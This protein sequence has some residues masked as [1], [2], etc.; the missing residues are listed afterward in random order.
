MSI[1]EFGEENRELRSVF[2]VFRDRSCIAHDWT[3][4]EDDVV[5]AGD[6]LGVFEF[7]DG[8]SEAIVAPTA[9]RIVRLFRPPLGTLGGRPS[10]VLALFDERVVRASAARASSKRSGRKPG[11]KTPPRKKGR[12]KG[13]NRRGRR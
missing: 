10:Q 11:R 8:S 3:A 2:S 9:G 7:D 13:G 4:Q 1:V 12:K 5:Q 6:A